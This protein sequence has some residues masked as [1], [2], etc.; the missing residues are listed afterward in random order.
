MPKVMLVEDDEQLRTIYQIRLQGEGYSV[1]LAKDGEEGLALAK[2][3]KPDLIIA[4]IMM[5]KV[6]GFAMLEVLKNTDGLKD[7]K[8]IMLTALGQSEDEER[9]KSLGADR[10]FVKTQVS[11]EDIAAAAKALLAEQAA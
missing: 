6:S 8:V 11:L 3:D 4:D 10:Y 9:A 5:P 1:I 2:A 7:I